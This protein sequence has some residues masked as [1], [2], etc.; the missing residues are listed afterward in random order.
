MAKGVEKIDITTG[1][2][3]IRWHPWVQLS[4][5]AYRLRREEHKPS[6][7]HSNDSNTNPSV[8][9]TQEEREK[10]YKHH[11][12]WSAHDHD[13]HEARRLEVLLE[14][15]IEI[16]LLSEDDTREDILSS[17][18]ENL[19]ELLVKPCPHSYENPI[20]LGGFLLIEKD[21]NSAIIF[22]LLE[23]FLSWYSGVSRGK[24]NRPK[25][26][27]PSPGIS[28][29]FGGIRPD[30]EWVL[31]NF[32]IYIGNCHTIFMWKFTH[33]EELTSNA[34]YSPVMALPA[35]TRTEIYRILSVCSAFMA[36]I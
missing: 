30:I 6:Y 25:A 4:T 33:T 3:C 14:F 18:W 27:T 35:H 1:S 23:L 16:I 20:F 22:L 11:D 24:E 12:I 32:S 10:N 21:R 31:Q 2:H 8:T 9:E 26:V 13:V 29:R 34:R 28:E 36:M 7:C 5:Q 19:R 17:R 15:C